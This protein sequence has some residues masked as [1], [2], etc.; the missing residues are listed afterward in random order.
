MGKMAAWYAVECYTKHPVTGE[1]GWDI[2]FIFVQATSPQSAVELAARHVPHY[3]QMITCECVGG[4]EPLSGCESL[5][6][7]YGAK[8]PEQLGLRAT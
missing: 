5:V 3:D 7:R 4:P 1:G 2:K 8:E 6:L